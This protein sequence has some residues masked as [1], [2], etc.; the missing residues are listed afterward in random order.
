M[1]AFLKRHLLV[2]IIMLF[3]VSL[4]VTLKTFHDATRWFALSQPFG[5]P[6]THAKTLRLEQIGNITYVSYQYQVS[7]SDGV[8]VTYTNTVDIRDVSL[9]TGGMNQMFQDQIPIEYLPDTPEY[10]M[11]SKNRWP[12]MYQNQI[13]FSIV[14]KWWQALPIPISSALLSIVCL[15]L[16]IRQ[17]RKYM[18]Q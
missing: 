7:N 16:F 6:E 11:V 15:I 10:S 18:Q 3:I 8:S 9:E 2:V 4:G 12:D 1:K 14:E 5:L 17:I 13:Q